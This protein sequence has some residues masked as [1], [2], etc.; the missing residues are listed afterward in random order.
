LRLLFSPLEFNRITNVQVWGRGV[1][2]EKFSPKHRSKSFR[3]NLGVA[4]E[5][6]IILF[7]GRLVHEKRPDIFAKVIRRLEALKV[8]YHALIVGAGPCDT[9]VKD[10]PNTTCLG[11][12][13]GSQLCEAYASS[14]IFLFP[15][16]VE[17]FG[18]VTLEAAASG[19]PLVVE[20][21]CSGH[22]VKHGINGFACHAGNEDEFFEATLKLIQDASMRENFSLESL[23]VSEM[24]EQRH[25]CKKMVK[26]YTMVTDEFYE[27]YHG[28]HENRDDEF[29]NSDSFRGGTDPRPFGMTII[30]FFFVHVFFRFLIIAVNITQC[31]GG[32]FKCAVFS[33]LCLK[34]SKNKKT[35]C[36]EDCESLDVDPPLDQVP[37]LSDSTDEDSAT[38]SIDRVSKNKSFSLAQIAIS[39]GESRFAVNL[40]IFCLGIVLFVWR[41]SSYIKRLVCSKFKGGEWRR[42]RTKSSDVENKVAR[43][44][45]NVLPTESG[46]L[47]LKQ[48][49]RSPNSVVT[50]V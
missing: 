8:Q 26:N 23:R 10:L 34:R 36:V 5:I 6:P 17:T 50:F 49:N 28:L 4:D 45:R 25:V 40:A 9:M 19:L 29:Q 46:D 11:W 16:S 42:V 31:V 41:F 37:L 39:I 15:S 12:L 20:G 22:L 7:T 43:S 2:L 35:E 27:K 13:S 21:G 33:K 48:R 14:D 44:S 3:E 24:M 1:D 18:N 30:E 32:L 47:R 38:V